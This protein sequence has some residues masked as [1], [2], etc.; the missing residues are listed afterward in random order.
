[1]ILSTFL[2]ALQLCHQNMKL[3]KSY[4]WEQ[5]SLLHLYTPTPDAVTDLRVALLAANIHRNRYPK[6]LDLLPPDRFR[7]KPVRDGVDGA[8]RWSDYI[9]AVYLDGA[10]LRDDVILT[11]TPSTPTLDDF[12]LLVD[13]EKVGSHIR[14][15]DSSIDAFSLIL[16]LIV[17]SVVRF[18]FGVFFELITR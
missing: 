14:H 15:Y 7:P 9:N 1:M 17:L 10:G 11:Q 18:Y 5:W 3:G 8:L 16:L 2:R 13:E 12:W 4:L 6:Q